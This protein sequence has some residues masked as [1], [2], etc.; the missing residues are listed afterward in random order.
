ML[1]DYTINFEDIDLD[2]NFNDID[3]N[4]NFD[5]LENINIDLADIGT[6]DI[7]SDITE[8]LNFDFED[9]DLSLDNINLNLE[10]MKG[11]KENE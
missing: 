11:K 2:L 1:E 6:E 10:E 9:I 7:I 5:D 8:G 3:L 4:I